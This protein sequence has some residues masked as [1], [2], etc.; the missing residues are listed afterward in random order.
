MHGLLSSCSHVFTASRQA[1]KNYTGVTSIFD[2]W[3]GLHAVS[4]WRCCTPAVEVDVEAVRS[5][6]HHVVD[7]LSSDPVLYLQWSHTNYSVLWM[8]PAI[9]SDWACL[10]TTYSITH[11]YTEYFVEISIPDMWLRSS[12]VGYIYIYIHSIRTLRHEY[13]E[14][15]L[16]VDNQQDIHTHPTIYKAIEY[17]V[18]SQPASQPAS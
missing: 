12:I 16:L 15:V 1:K 3:A 18:L 10:C 2:G 11:L 14:V 4:Q 8:Q 13:G 5:T 9:L 6:H 7:I 17:G